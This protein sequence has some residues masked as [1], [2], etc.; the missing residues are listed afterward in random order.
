MD[1]AAPLA[2]LITLG[3][4]DFQRERD[5]YRA[6]GWPIAFDSDDFVAFELQGVVL[7]LFPLDKLA[8]DS[9]ARPEVGQGGIRF[10]VIISVNTPEEVDRLADRARAAGAVVT[11]P[12]TEAE[13]FEGRD[14]YFSD[15]EGN[16]WEIAYAPADNPVVVAFSTRRRV[17]LTRRHSPDDDLGA[18]VRAARRGSVPPAR[19]VTSRGGGVRDLISATRP[20]TLRGQSVTVREY[21]EN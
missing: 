13:F 21:P 3:V 6:L 19:P 8:A 17:R 7:T 18:R 15:P 10:S 9:R 5:F 20:L 14:A 16:F 12:P 1:S 4:Q 11:K 2:N